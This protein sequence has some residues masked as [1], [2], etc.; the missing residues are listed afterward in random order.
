[1]NCRHKGTHNSGELG[2][3]FVL[4]FYILYLYFILVNKA[5]RLYYIQIPSYLNIFCTEFLKCLFL[6]LLRYCP[7]LDSQD[8]CPYVRIGPRLHRL[9]RR[10]THVD[11]AGTYCSTHCNKCDNKSVIRVFLTLLN[12]TVVYTW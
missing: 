12:F 5:T 9:S 6:L 4:Y 7:G 2:L 10:N 1:M 11:A 3:Y 8:L